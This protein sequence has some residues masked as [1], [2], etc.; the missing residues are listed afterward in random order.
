MTHNANL[1]GVSR[2]WTSDVLKI[3]GMKVGELRYDRNGKMGIVWQWRS[4]DNVRLAGGG[5]GGTAPIGS[6]ESSGTVVI[7][8]AR[9]LRS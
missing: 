7:P 3:R 5:F 9:V 8:I 4:G 1:L 6:S 2:V